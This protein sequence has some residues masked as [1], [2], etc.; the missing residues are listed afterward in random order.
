MEKQIIKQVKT[1][2]LFALVSIGMACNKTNDATSPIA[3]TEY[4]KTSLQYMREEE[5]LAR[6]VYQYLYTVHGTAIFSNIANSEQTHM[7]A[8]KQLLLKYGI[9]DPAQDDTRGAFTNAHLQ[10]LYAQL[11]SAGE[12]SPASGLRVGATIEDLDLFD[13]GTE[14]DKVTNVDIVRVYSSLSKGSRNHLRS[15][16]AQLLTLGETYTPQY[17]SAEEFNSIINSPMETGN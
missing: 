17:I 10:D 9:T 1:V 6:D 2:F 13:L 8:I 11:T 7:D 3:V 15:F 16:Y 5:K 4:E 14:L 12:I